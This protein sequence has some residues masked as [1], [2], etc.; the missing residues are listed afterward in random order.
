MNRQTHS[1]ILGSYLCQFTPSQLE[2]AAQLLKA[3]ATKNQ[4][5]ETL[6]N[7]IDDHGLGNIAHVVINAPLLIEEN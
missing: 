3:G 4:V 5:A 1:L 7:R 2:T 6:I